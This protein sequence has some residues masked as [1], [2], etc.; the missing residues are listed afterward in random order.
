[1]AVRT[2]L[3]LGAGG[4]T[5]AAWQAGMIAGL[6]DLGLDLRADRVIGTSAGALVAA[7]LATGSDP[8]RLAQALAAPLA[9]LRPNPW[10]LPLR[11]AVVQLHPSHKHAIRAVGR[12]AIRDWTPQWQALRIQQLAPDLVGVSW[13]ESLLIIATDAVTGR[14]AYF[15][16][17]EPVDIAT[18]IA[19]SW[20]VPGAQPA[21]QTEGR[22]FVDGGLR[23][24]LNADT[25]TGADSVIAL[26]ALTG[27][28]DAALGERH[29]VQALRA[30]GS[31]VRV[32]RP[33]RSAW[34]AMATEADL[35]R[36]VQATLSAGREQGRRY[37]AE[38]AGHWPG[39]A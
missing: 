28:A 19:A 24:P 8:Q 2:A 6:A 26:A 21:V 30:A 25:A 1:M 13:P 15:S 31:T 14:P 16:A 3:V 34:L 7:R 29:H 4:V 10:T 22:W 11:R 39:I 35:G 27:L 36:G 9:W 33:D 37:G 20:S 23:S 5:A 32:V 17:R 38:L 18:A 12:S